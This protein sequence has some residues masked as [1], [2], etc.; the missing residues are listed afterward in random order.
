VEAQI[1]N[2]ILDFNSSA[3]EDFESGEGFV[4]ARKGKEGDRRLN[5]QVG[6]GKFNILLVLHT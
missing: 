1:E 5:V 4:K 2:G 6:S 3:F